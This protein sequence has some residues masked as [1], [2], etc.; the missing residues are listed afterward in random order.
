MKW[1]ERLVL[2]LV[3]TGFLCSSLSVPLLFLPVLYMC[4]W[5]ACQIYQVFGKYLC[6]S[7][8]QQEFSQCCVSLPHTIHWY[9]SC[10]IVAH[11][12]EA[13]VESDE[14]CQAGGSTEKPKTASA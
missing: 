4:D 11:L 2:L 3:Y 8:C 10:E 12:T 1:K 6:K 7:L 14:T 5:L 13:K 9:G